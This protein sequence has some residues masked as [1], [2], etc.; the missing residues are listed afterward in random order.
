MLIYRRTNVTRG[1]SADKVSTDH[2]KYTSLPEECILPPEPIDPSS[3]CF[4]VPSQ[5]RVLTT[6]TS[7][8]QM[9]LHFLDS[10]L[11]CA[12][13]GIVATGGTWYGTKTI[14]SMRA[15]RNVKKS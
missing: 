7:S 13:L 9:V 11:E 3:K 4:D 15:L 6:A 8:Q 14:D 12:V 1:E 10:G 2:P 5:R